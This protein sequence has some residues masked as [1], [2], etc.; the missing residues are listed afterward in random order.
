MYPSIDRIKE[1]LLKESYISPEDSAAAEGSAKDS[2]GYIDYLIREGVLSK[3]LLGQ[4]LGEG[5]KLPF[6]DLEAYPPAKDLVLL[7]PEAMA[8]NLRVVAVKKDDAGMQVA[9]DS[10]DK[11]D[12]H[13][14]LTL[15]P[16]K[17][18]RLAYTLPE[19]LDAAYE[20]YEQPLATRFSK[21]INESNRVAPEVVDEIIKDA[22]GFRASDI[23]FEPRGEHVD[24]R[25]RVDGALREAGQ[26][27]KEYYDNILNRIKVESGMRIDE[28]L[29][30]QDGAMQRQATGRPVDLRVSLVPTVEGEKVVMRVLGS[31]VQGFSFSD[32]GFN[33]AHREIIERNIAKPFGMILTVGPTGS[34]KSTTLYSLLKM[35]NKPDVNI[36][37]IEDPVEYKMGGTNQIQ[38]R[39]T[40]GMTFAKGLRAI[41]RQDPDIILVGEIRDQETAEISVNAALTGHL[42]LSTFHANDAATAM[43][44][45]VEMGIE[46]FLLSS[47][48]EVIIAQRLVRTICS[49]C[50]YSMTVHEAAADVHVSGFDV[51]HYFRPTDTVYGGKGCNV[52][53]GSGYQGRTAV[54]EIIEMTPEM[55]ELMVQS[56]STQQVESLARQQG[57]RPMFDDGVDKVKRGLTTIKEVLRVVSP[58][59]VQKEAGE[60]R[61]PAAYRHVEPAVQPQVKPDGDPSDD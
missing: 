37:T 57:S 30:A 9:T 13:Q 5:Y 10:P 59:K 45:L 19:Y 43:P 44:R 54:F 6:A 60:P 1:L 56:P 28:H 7:V 36:T 47:T 35:L 8:R 49:H 40:A 20:L 23:H 58:P 24:V 26:L 50:R 39:D 12:P 11:L 53:S 22:L 29:T 3:A 33:D 27:P 17:K 46:P 55:Q 34:G 42:L 25:F 14:L 61:R 16:G 4:A 32:V 41:V 38:V 2:N 18:V 15:F 21:I 48:L 52:C 51:N 31:Y